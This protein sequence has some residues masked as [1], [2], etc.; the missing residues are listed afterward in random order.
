MFLRR[1]KFITFGHVVPYRNEKRRDRRVSSKLIM[2]E[3]VKGERAKK[4]DL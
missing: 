1:G 3:I 4:G 2:K